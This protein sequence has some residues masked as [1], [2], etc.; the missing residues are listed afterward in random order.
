MSK[1]LVTLLFFLSLV[2]LQAKDS[3]KGSSSDNTRLD[4]MQLRKMYRSSA[5]KT[6]K[7]YR[8][9]QMTF[10]GKVFRL[11]SRRNHYELSLNKGL[12][13]LTVD[14]K[15]LSEDIVKRI[16]DIRRNKAVDAVEV[17]FSGVWSRTRVDILLMKDGNN[18]V[19]GEDLAPKGRRGRQLAAASKKKKN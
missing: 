9:K 7:E 11:K 13:K 18:F 4:V 15:N 8:N 10:S 1:I 14:K 17:T 12:I 2:N 16:Q 5:L 3:E 6:I 19:L